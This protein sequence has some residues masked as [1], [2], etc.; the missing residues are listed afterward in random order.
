MPQENGWA[1]GPEHCDNDEQNELHEDLRDHD[2]RDHVRILRE[3]AEQILLE[4][5]QNPGAIPDDIVAGAR[6]ALEAT[7]EGA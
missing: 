5:E 1:T 2:A 6:R 4:E 7:K 3:L